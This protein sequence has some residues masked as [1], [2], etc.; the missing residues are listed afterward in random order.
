MYPGCLDLSRILGE[1]V[2]MG[3]YEAF[4]NDSWGGEVEN[5]Q[6]KIRFIATFEIESQYGLSREPMS[7][8]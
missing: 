4:W 5:I 1:L 6:R 3:V 7:S 8:I 2:L